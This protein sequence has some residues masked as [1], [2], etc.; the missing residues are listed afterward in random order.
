MTDTP[1]KITEAGLRD[2]GARLLPPQSVLLSSRAP[3]G[4]VAINTVPMATNQGF[5]SLA[6]DPLQVDAKYLYHWLRANRSYLKGLGNGATFKEIS[7][8]VISRVEIPLPQIVEQCGIAEILDQAEMLRA[9]RHEALAQLDELAQSIFLGMFGDPMTN[10]MR[11]PRTT[12]AEVLSMPLRNG[13]VSVKRWKI[14]G[15]SAHTFGDHRKRV[16]CKCTEVGRLRGGTFPY[17]DC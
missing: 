4:H 6:P 17:S 2:C 9:K 10:S 5:K 11:W 12:L 16:Q 7:K 1:R 15:Q 3:I 8:E 13:G 14:S